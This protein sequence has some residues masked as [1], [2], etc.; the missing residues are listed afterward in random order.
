M[1]QE[2]LFIRLRGDGQV[3]WLLRGDAGPSATGQVNGLAALADADSGPPHTAAQVILIVPGSDV[4]LRAVELPVRSLA[5]ARTAL[6]WL[7][8]DDMAAAPDSQH[9]AMSSPDDAG[10]RLA[11]AAARDRMESWT[12]ALAAAGLTADR[13]LPDF[14]LLGATPEN[15]VIVAEEGMVLFALGDAAG[16]ACEPDL[17]A[18]LL[19]ALLTDSACRS[20]DLYGEDALPSA[21]LPEGC[22][23]RRLPALPADE[24]LAL[25]AD[26]VARR[27]EEGDRRW[28]DLAQG[29][30]APRRE[31][32]F[33]P[34]RI[35][36]LA[37]LAAALLVAHV[38]TVILDARDYA[39]RALVAEQR[40]EAAF[41]Q[42]A[43]EGSRI[44]NPRAQLANMKR[45]LGGQGGGFIDL[46]RML[47]RAV[48]AQPGVVLQALTY[49]ARSQ[50]LRVEAVL[51]DFADIEALKSNL[52][53][54]GGVL[55][56]SGAR[57][58][59]GRI[60]GEFTLKEA[61]S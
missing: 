42:V 29:P 14:A 39:D 28:P 18:R 38:A 11:L 49:D 1:A 45:R 60:L 35:K 61:S 15:A 3:D 54:Q 46:S 27:E 40:I 52:K 20:V 22:E 6:P 32:V 9:V 7:L 5:Q 17:A 31:R 4:L 30:Y 34:G 51:R 58:S 21:A 25:M 33:S 47:Y 50:S 59:E 10:R 23:S 48:S 19:P 2:T 36:R 41:R 37:M 16:G 8:E 13:I 53:A 24:L 44:V 26:T 56:D 43:P 55:E 12:S 57:Q